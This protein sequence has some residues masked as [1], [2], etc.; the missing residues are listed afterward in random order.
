L[1]K[2]KVF[3]ILKSN[4]LTMSR[5]KR[6]NKLLRKK[7]LTTSEELIKQGKLDPY[8]HLKDHID[9]KEEQLKNKTDWWSKMS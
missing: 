2:T 3:R 5:K 6:Q 1:I 4:R 7:Y 8:F 9:M